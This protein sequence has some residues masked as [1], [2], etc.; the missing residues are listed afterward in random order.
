MLIIAQV[1]QAVQFERVPASLLKSCPELRNRYT[2]GWVYGH[3]DAGG[4]DYFIVS[5]LMR[6][7][8]EKSG[9]ATGKVYPDENGIIVAV[10]NATCSMEAQDDFYWGTDSPVWKLSDAAL[11]ELASD[12][13]HRYSK[14]FG[15]KK[16]FLKRA[17]ARDWKDFAPPLRKQLEALEHQQ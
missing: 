1:A 10:Q 8:D 3:S 13:L 14:A 17:H 7:F 9:K 6:D 2:S 16:T 5:G 4:V 11:N 12:V 15:G